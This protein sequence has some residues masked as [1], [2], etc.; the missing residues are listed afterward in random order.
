MRSRI[1]CMGLW[2]GLVL[3]LQGCY[4]DEPNGQ[5]RLG[6]DGLGVEQQALDSWI[7]WEV[8]ERPE[9][10]EMNTDDKNLFLGIELRS[11]DPLASLDLVGGLV[12]QQADQLWIDLLIG[13]CTGCSLEL[14]VFAH[15]GSL[16][17]YTG[18]SAAFDVP[19]PAGEDVVVD[20]EL[21]ETG[22]LVIET[23]PAAAAALR[24]AA[25]DDQANLRLPPVTT[26]LVDQRARAVLADMPVGRQL[27]VQVERDGAWTSIGSVLLDHAGQTI[28]IS[29]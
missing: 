9:P 11:Q 10:Y 5:V 4:P 19:L 8:G 3:G 17:V 7:A 24:V 15:L 6:L 29:D 2:L 16:Q 21:A 22:S 12:D 26:E 1:S 18:T 27:I 20:A 25:L 13:D 14:V 28:T 23:E